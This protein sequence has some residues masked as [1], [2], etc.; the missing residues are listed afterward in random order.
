MTRSS[1]AA[2]APSQERTLPHNLEAEQ[3]VLGGLLLAAHQGADED[4]DE[5]LAALRREVF[6]AERHSLIF[7]AMVDVRTAGEA[8][9][10]IVVTDRLR[11]TGKLDG[12]GGAAYVT[13]LM[14]AAWTPALLSSQVKILLRDWR[15]RALAD[16]GG[17]LRQAALNGHEAEELLA[18][19][20]RVTAD[21]DSFPAIGVGTRTDR[22][23]GA[24]LAGDTAS[25][26]VEW[27]PLLRLEGIVGRGLATLIS[28]HAKTGKTTLLVHAVRKLLR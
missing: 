28:S 19:T 26:E 17:E 8:P 27:V 24:T 3:A 16:L 4:L 22:I 9:G 10:L 12:A 15:K 11:Q 5:A 21:I 14:E 1:P 25:P 18:L 7:G 23:D 13:S 6:Y 2:K 20:R